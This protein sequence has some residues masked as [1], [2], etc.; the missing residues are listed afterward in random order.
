[1]DYPVYSAQPASEFLGYFGE[2]EL[3]PLLRAKKCFLIGVGKK[4]R[5]IMHSTVTDASTVLKI[6]DRE[7]RIPG[8]ALSTTQVEQIYQ[9]TRKDGPVTVTAYLRVVKRAVFS[10]IEAGPNAGSSIGEFVGWN[11]SDKFPRKRF[12]PDKLRPIFASV[13]DMVAAGR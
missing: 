9:G 13:R 12:N 10:K 11:E 7:D 4:P 6:N 3:R 2:D 1:M 8:G 5:V